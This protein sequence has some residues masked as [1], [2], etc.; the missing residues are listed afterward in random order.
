M[1]TSDHTDQSAH[2]GANQTTILHISDTHLGYRQY[3]SDLRRTDFLAAFSQG[4]DLAIEHDVDAVIHTGDLF[5]MRNPPNTVLLACISTLHELS[6]ND[7]PFYGIVGNHERKQDVQHLDLIHETDVADRLDDEPTVINGDVAL[8]GID[9]VPQPVWSSREFDLAEPPGDCFTILTMHELLAPPLPE[10][11]ADHELTDVLNRLDIDLD[12][13]ALGDDHTPRSDRVDGIE[14]WYPGSTERTAS[15]QQDQRSVQ[16]LEIA[17]AT[18]TRTR[19]P[20]D[21][22]PFHDIQVQFDEGD[23][24]EHVTDVLNQ[25]NFANGVVEITLA[26]E[27]TATSSRDVRRVALDKGAAVCQVKDQRG[28]PELDPTEGPTGNAE[29]IDHRIESRIEKLE[30]SAI[31]TEIESDLRTGS[32]AST[33]LADDIQEDIETAMN[34]AHDDILTTERGNE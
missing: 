8:Y 20:L 7:I 13:I 34:T 30:M 33:G 6:A 24:L 11:E 26:G 29:S 3:R 32:P 21:T 27:P 16:L 17:D 2:S 9:S 22:R 14:V 18:L 25:H 31:V 15:D 4:V 10:I 19:L 28:G 12:A 23:M 5:D 1:A